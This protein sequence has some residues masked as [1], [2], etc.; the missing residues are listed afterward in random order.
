MPWL[1]IR[2]TL[3]AF[4]TPAI[5][6]GTLFIAYQQWQTNHSKFKFER[7]E[8]RLRVYEEVRKILSIVLRDANASFDELLRFRAAVS[9]ADFLFGPEIPTYLDEIYRKGVALRTATEQYRDSTQFTPPG[10]DHGKVVD[11]MHTA[12][13][14]LTSQFEPAKAK[15]RPYLD[16]SK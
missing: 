8:K 7:Y 3:A 14:W 6:I 9:E 5:G 2:D 16:V 13:T 15:F 10:Y 4:L 12:L 1:E 11:Q